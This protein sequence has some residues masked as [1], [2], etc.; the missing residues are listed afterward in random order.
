MLFVAMLVKFSIPSLD[1]SWYFVQFFYP[2]INH[3]VDLKIAF[4]CTSLQ[5]SGKWDYIL[6]AFLPTI[7]NIGQV[8][9][10]DNEWMQ[11]GL[12]TAR[13]IKVE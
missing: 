13:E 4:S 12:N 11:P 3:T 1:F 9:N 8:L 6:F 7:C 2:S 5:A 10:K